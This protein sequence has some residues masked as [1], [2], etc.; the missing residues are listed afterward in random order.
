[1]DKMIYFTSDQHFGHTNIIKYCNRPY[2]NVDRMDNQLI[3]NWNAEIGESDVVY[4]L[5]D[6]TL[7][8]KGHKEWLREVLRRLNGHKHLILGNHDVMPA[9]TY[10]DIGFESVHTS[11]HVEIP[12]I[13]TVNLVHD[14]ALAVTDRDA[15]FLCGHVHTLY[16][17]VGNVINVGV[18]VWKY[19]PVSEVQICETYHNKLEHF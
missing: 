13:G 2:K 8:N 9:F 5:G 3:K 4:V 19:A 1:V 14:P 16:T 11:Y 17:K 18:D 7:K 15:L 12:K 6:V 10:V